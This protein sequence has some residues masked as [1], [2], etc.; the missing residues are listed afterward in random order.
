[1]LPLFTD[2]NQPVANPARKL[3]PLR[4]RPNY[5]VTTSEFSGS[6]HYPMAR[7]RVHSEVLHQYFKEDDPKFVAKFSVA[8]RDETGIAARQPDRM[9]LRQF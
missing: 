7:W 1:M 8:G 4:E 9:S 2:V 5:R 6:L 3:L